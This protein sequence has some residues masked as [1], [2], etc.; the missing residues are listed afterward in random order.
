MNQTLLSPGELLLKRRELGLTQNQVADRLGLHRNTIIR[1]ERNNNTR[2]RFSADT[3]REY[4]DLLESL[5]LK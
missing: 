5:S 4:A 2:S 3:I 1:I